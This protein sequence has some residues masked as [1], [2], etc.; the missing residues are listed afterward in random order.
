MHATLIYF[1][2]IFVGAS[3]YSQSEQI[4][5]QDNARKLVAQL[6][7]VATDEHELLE[8]LNSIKYGNGPSPICAQSHPAI[9]VYFVQDLSNLISHDSKSVRQVL[10]T[11]SWKFE[12]PS[13][14]ID[15]YRVCHLKVSECKPSL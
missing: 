8:V 13:S 14:G 4:S 15:D 11:F 1:H 12:T 5:I 6:Q 7:S 3:N 10:E 9:L 2:F